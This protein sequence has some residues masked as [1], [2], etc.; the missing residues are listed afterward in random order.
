MERMFHIFDFDK[1][2]EFL[3]KVITAPEFE[4]LKEL[5]FFLHLII[6]SKGCRT[7]KFRDFSKVDLITL[8]FE[9]IFIKLYEGA[10]FFIM[11]LLCSLFK[12]RLL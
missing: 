10:N 7:T 9:L 2:M 4:F 8:I 11:S 12:N 3:L 5:K 6:K 1:L